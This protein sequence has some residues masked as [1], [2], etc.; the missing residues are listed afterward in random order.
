M[1][2]LSERRLEERVGEPKVDRAYLVEGARDFGGELD[3][4]ATEDVVKLVEPPYS[5]GQNEAPLTPA[6]QGGGQVLPRKTTAGGRMQ[7]DSRDRAAS[8]SDEACRKAT[9]DVALARECP[10]VRERV[11][12][13]YP[14]TQDA[15]KQA[16]Q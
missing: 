1:H 2:Q 13:S 7:G 4:G 3:L 5:H 11:P 10:P 12:V 9:P 16:T 6:L 14:R 15:P 8:W